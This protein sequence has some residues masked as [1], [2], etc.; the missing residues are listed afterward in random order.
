MRGKSGQTGEEERGGE[1]VNGS[2]KNAIKGRREK[3]KDKEG[4]KGRRR[5]QGVH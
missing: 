5:C 2:D 3:M 1:G 4:E